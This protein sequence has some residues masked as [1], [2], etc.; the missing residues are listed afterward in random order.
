MTWHHYL[1]DLNPVTKTKNM[2]KVILFA[3]VLALTSTFTACN[4]DKTGNDATEGTG[5]DTTTV[6]QADNTKRLELPCATGSV[7]P[8]VFY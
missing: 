2:K 8:V 1:N 6:R 5:T 7:E 3:F 4:N